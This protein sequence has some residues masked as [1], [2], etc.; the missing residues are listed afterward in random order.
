M[1]DRRSMSSADEAAGP[2]PD[3]ARSTVG[4]GAVVVR[5]DRILLVRLTYGWAAGRWLI[6]NGALQPGETVAQT[7]LRELAEEAGLQGR[8]GALVAVRSLAS[9][10]GSDTFIA[11]SVHA[12]SG[13][14][15]PDGAEVD[16]ARFF[17]RAEIA[18]LAEQKRIVRLHRLIAERVL[19]GP[20][21][22]PVLEMPALDRQGNPATALLYLPAG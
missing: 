6:P 4:A 16:A 12:L 22:P 14:P 2:A 11:L 1:A 17:D 7:A 20:T 18:A 5:D 10:L 15:R 3:G 13:D 8:S 9:R 19:P 21:P